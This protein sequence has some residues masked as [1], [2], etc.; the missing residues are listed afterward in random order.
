VAHGCDCS[1]RKVARCLTAARN[2]ESAL[3][4]ERSR[5]NEIDE[6]NARARIVAS[7]NKEDRFM[8]SNQFFP[9]RQREDLCGGIAE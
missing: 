8:V 2:A 7:G 9:G 6:R 1:R 5:R 4:E 3:I